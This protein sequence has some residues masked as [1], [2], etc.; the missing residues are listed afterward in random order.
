MVEGHNFISDEGEEAG[1]HDAGPAPLRYFLGGIMMCHQVWCVKSAAVAEYPAKLKSAAVT[2]RGKSKE[3]FP[4]SPTRSIL[5]APARRKPFNPL[6]MR[7]PGVARRLS[8]RHGRS[9]L[10]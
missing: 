10:S 5:K 9:P 4:E 3:V 7:P 8:R 2:V 6:S 1:G